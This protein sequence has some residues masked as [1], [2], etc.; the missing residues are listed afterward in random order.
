MIFGDDLS[1][2]MMQREDDDRRRRLAR[3]ALQSLS[4]EQALALTNFILAHREDIESDIN[5]Y[6]DLRSL[7]SLLYGR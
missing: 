3:Y 6:G 4:A 7:L 5:D 2:G 1:A